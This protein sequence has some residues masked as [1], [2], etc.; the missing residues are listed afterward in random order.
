MARPVLFLC[1]IAF[2]N[3]DLSGVT[4]PL[5]GSI[6]STISN[7]NYLTTLCG[8]FDPSGNV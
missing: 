3:S 6:P 5:T 8:F 2:L 4:S 1:I 7:L